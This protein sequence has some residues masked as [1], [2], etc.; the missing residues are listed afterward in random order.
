MY[1]LVI[2]WLVATELD[3]ENQDL[4]PYLIS[5]GGKICGI[6][7]LLIT[8]LEAADH[9]CAPFKSNQSKDAHEVLQS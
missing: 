3:K 5:H 7:G 9:V 6:G 2:I 8:H 4:P 1:F